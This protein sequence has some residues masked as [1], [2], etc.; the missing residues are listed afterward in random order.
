MSTR[1]ALDISREREL[2]LVEI[3]PQASPPVC[4]II[5]WSKFKYEYS[6]KQKLS[7]P[8]SSKMKE[9][10]FYPMIGEGDMEHKVKKIREFLE[11]KSK[12]RITVKAVR[13]KMRITPKHFYNTIN[14]VIS[15]L[16]DVAEVETPPKSEGR[17]VYAI[18][19]PKK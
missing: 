11:E 4:K 10:R 8:T 7:K 12:V 19:K 2:D 6:K 9:M 14:K 3:A 5:D 13:S 18:I 15:S 17:N 1:E 16:D